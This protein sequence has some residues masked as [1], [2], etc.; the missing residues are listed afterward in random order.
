MDNQ[1]NTIQ[2][3]L[4]TKAELNARLALLPYIGTPEIK[5]ISAFLI[6]VKDHLM[7]FRGH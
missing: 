1:F 2:E 6:I 7:F 5:M 3:L 4:R